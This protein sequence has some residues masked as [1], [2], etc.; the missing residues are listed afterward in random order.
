[1]FKIPSDTKEYQ[2]NNSSDRQGNVHITKNIN[3]DND[4][5]ISLSDRTRSIGDSSNLSDLIDGS[6]LAPVLAVSQYD[7]SLYMLSNE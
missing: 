1:M 6:K 2:Q 5:Y 4:G 7:L 3:F